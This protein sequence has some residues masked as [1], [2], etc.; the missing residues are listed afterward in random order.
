MNKIS[1]IT[2]AVLCLILGIALAIQFK[3]TNFNMKQAK[4]VNL[5]RDQLMTEF[6]REREK[7]E[8][9]TKQLNELEKKVQEYVNTEITNGGA[10]ELLQ[11][12]LNEAQILSGLTEVKGDG[13]II[14]FDNSDTDSVVYTDLLDL[15]NEL[16]ASGA[17]AISI[18]DERV[19]A[20][21]EVRKA[22]AFIVINNTKNNAPFI[23]K[24]VGNPDTLEA[25]LKMRDG[26]FERYTKQ[27][28]LYM[29]IEKSGNITIPKYSGIISVDLLKPVQD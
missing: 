24:A 19:I 12:R 25:S 9:L 21:T 29:N 20:T 17:V 15:L 4:A 7:A 18:N 13:I 27:Y 23:I 6:L 1:S 22:G 11:K 10:S 28:S 5:S 2:L 16:R 3:S 26:V 8:N 14:R